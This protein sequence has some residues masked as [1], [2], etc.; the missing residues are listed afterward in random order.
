MVRLDHISLPVRDW[1]RARDW[2]KQHLGFEVEFEIP[3]RKTAV[4]RDSA[5]L[6]VFLYEGEVAV[7]RMSL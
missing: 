3:E 2:Y 1:R 5:D 6:T 4:M 7:R